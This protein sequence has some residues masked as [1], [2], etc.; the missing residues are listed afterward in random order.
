M[1]GAGAGLVENGAIR[2][3]ISIPKT[4]LLL[5][6]SIVLAAGGGALC[7]GLF[8]T[9]GDLITP[10]YESSLLW[11]II[12]LV[13]TL[14]M[15]A[16]GFV[17]M[18]FF[19]YGTIFLLTR[20]L[21]FWRPVVEIT[22]ERITDRSNMLSPGLVIWDEIGTA[23][24]TG[25]GF[26]VVKVKDE[27]KLIR[28]QNPIKG[29]GMRVNSRYF[30]G[31]AINIPVGSLPISE[32]ELLL[33]IKP[34]LRPS[35]Q[36]RLEERLAKSSSRTS[37]DEASQSGE[38]PQKHPVA[39]KVLLLI[40]FLLQRAWAALLTIGFICTGSML[41]LFGGIVGWSRLRAVFGFGSGLGEWWHIPVGAIMLVIGAL[42][43][44]RMDRAIRK[45]SGREPV[46]SHL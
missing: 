30:T 20:I 15:F 44:L 22:R 2:V 4:V 21:L 25:N 8:Y 14:P 40:L 23:S 28:Q 6:G 37:K 41:G 31:H 19:G 10:S 9:L 7:L 5:L 16:L 39:H 36:E 29:L 17:G 45:L 43:F 3:R 27:Q 12:S 13:V 18:V 26:I 42:V 35:A 24:P 11:S 38:V 32:E 34:Y 33:E 1:R 46:D